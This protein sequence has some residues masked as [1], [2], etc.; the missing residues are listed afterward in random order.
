MFRLDSIVGG[1]GGVD[2][3]AAAA[4]P[5]AGAE[6]RDVSAGVFTPGPGDLLAVVDVTA[7]ARWAADHYPVESVSEL[8]DGGLR[9]TLYAAGTAWLRRL[10][11]GLGGEASAVGPAALVAEIHDAAGKALAGYETA[12][13]AG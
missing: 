12:E 4:A 13:P 3:L 10:L 5:P 7:R 1:A 11:L 8:P 2:V 6:V 9:L